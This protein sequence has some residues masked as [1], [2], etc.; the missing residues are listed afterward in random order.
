VITKERTAMRR[1][2][3]VIGMIASSTVILGSSSSL[4]AKT[5]DT[6]QPAS[7]YYQDSKLAKILDT[8]IRGHDE[9]SGFILLRKGDRALQERL[10]LADIAEHTI[11]AQYYIWNSDKSGKL[12]AQRLIQAGDR[13]VSVRVILDDFSIGDRNEQMLAVDSHPNIQIRIYNPFVNRSG[14]AK[15]LNFAFDFKRLNRRMHNKTY[16]VDEV[17]AIVGGRNIGDEYFDHNEHLNFRDLDLFTVGPVVVE[18]SKSFEEYW[19]SPWAIPIGQLVTTN[20]GQGDRSQLDILL[21]DNR[22]ELSQISPP[23]KAGSPES[24]FNQAVNELIWAPATFIFD[25]PGGEDKEA[26]SEGPKRVADH[27]LQL[28]QNS[29]NEILIESA[30]FVLDEPALEFAGRL[31]DRGVRIRA[32]TNSMASN[33]VLPNHASYAMV[34]EKMLTRG[35]EL[36]ELRPDAQSCLQ[37]VGHSVYCDE[38]SSL[39][40]HAKAAVFDRKTIYVGSCNLNLRSAYLNT[41]VG[42]F[43]DSPILAETLI[44]QIELNMKPEN[45]WQPKLKGNQVIWITEINGQEKII[46]HEPQTSWLERVKEG[47]LTLVPGAQYY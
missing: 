44:S 42:M 47:M 6:S 43:V 23:G 46:M 27:L 35:I 22:T 5:V 16:T 13:G 34:R 2:I 19:D 14:A 9:E 39:G 1:W 11:D 15:W 17:A 10:Y 20:S 26:Y 28:A 30:Y 45:S 31:R 37:T 18:V 33:D 7:K 21:D 25:R 4:P 29:E 41:E 32:L 12:L 24:H 8:V 38:D 3:L 36:Y 40:L